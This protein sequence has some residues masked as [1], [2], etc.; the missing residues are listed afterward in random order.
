MQC[1]L[2][3]LNLIM[4]AGTSKPANASN[5]AFKIPTAET[6]RPHSWHEAITASVMDG[7][8]AVAC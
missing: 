4:V 5:F 3:I 2:W 6:G 8:H 7:C 1:R